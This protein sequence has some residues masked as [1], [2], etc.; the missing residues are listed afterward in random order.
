MDDHIYG[1]V[2]ATEYVRF[3][4]ASSRCRK[5]S[6]WSEVSII[7]IGSNLSKGRRPIREAL[8]LWALTRSAEGAEIP[9]RVRWGKSPQGLGWV[10]L[11][12]FNLLCEAWLL[13]DGA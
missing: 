4:V 11:R 5:C 2:H 10:V 7:F 9:K 8:Y 3:K 13:L 6:P 1:L 12:L